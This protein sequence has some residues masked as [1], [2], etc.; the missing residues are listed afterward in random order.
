[1]KYFHIF[2]ISFIIIMSSCNKDDVK[3][4][5]NKNIL[6]GTW[7]VVN[8]L[9]ILKSDT[10]VSFKDGVYKEYSYGKVINTLYNS[11][12]S[13]QFKNDHEFVYDQVLDSDT[14][15]YSSKWNFKGTDQSNSFI[16]IDLIINWS[17]NRQVTFI[18]SIARILKIDEDNLI[19]ECRR[20]NKLSEYSDDNTYNYEGEDN[21]YLYYEL[22]KDENDPN[23]IDNVENCYTNSDLLGKWQMTEFLDSTYASLFSYNFKIADYFINDTLYSDHLVGLTTNEIIVEKEQFKSYYNL[24]ISIESN[25]VFQVD[26]IEKGEYSGLTVNTTKYGYWY[27]ENENEIYFEPMASEDGYY[28]NITPELVVFNPSYSRYK[29]EKNSAD[30]FTL[31]VI[32]DAHIQMYYIFNRIK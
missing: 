24:K 23:F 26:I 9:S 30:S 29:V 7:K 32:N 4:I 28:F 2:F 20:S 8:K 12:I 11:S 3:E 14:L 25:G 31:N 17:P 15:T 10:S 6:L 1:M 21:T 13:F 22:I 18:T 16:G 19:I 27:W 5:S